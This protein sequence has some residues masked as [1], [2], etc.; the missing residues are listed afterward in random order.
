[1][2]TPEIVLW[3][4]G[5]AAIGTV[6]FFVVWSLWPMRN[7][8]LMR[9]P[10]SGAIAFVEVKEIRLPGKTA[11]EPRVMRCDLWPLRKPCARGCLSRYHETAPGRRVSVHA[12]RPFEHP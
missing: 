1:M 9:C 4:T 5:L 12:L 11:P 10:E 3:I 8:R 6:V 7:A 2:S